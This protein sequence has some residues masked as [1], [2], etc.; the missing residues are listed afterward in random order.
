[1]KKTEEIQIEIEKCKEIKGLVNQ[2]ADNNEKYI[3]LHID[4]ANTIMPY[5]AKL[6]SYLTGKNY[7]VKKALVE[8]LL[9]TKEQKEKTKPKHN[10]PEKVVNT[11]YL[12]IRKKDWDWFKK[13]DTEEINF[14]MPNYDFF[15]QIKDDITKFPR[16]T[17][18]FTSKFIKFKK[19]EQS[20][21]IPSKLNEENKDNFTI[22]KNSNC[23]LYQNNYPILI[24]EEKTE[25]IKKF[26][27]GILDY[28]INNN[29][30]YIEED[31]LEEMYQKTTNE[32][33]ENKSEKTKK[34]F[35]KRIKEVFKGK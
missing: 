29:C 19:Y 17:T 20:S 13:L 1:M 7:I 24:P 30:Q 32:Y 12:I 3:N 16:G 2:L 35:S 10:N 27:K 21:K 14:H 15:V 5:I 26:L 4:D 11:H 6:T 23:L 34:T 28:K 18:L 22:G 25:Y 31:T 33:D 9:E 8:E